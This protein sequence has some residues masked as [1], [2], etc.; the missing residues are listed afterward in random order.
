MGIF[1]HILSSRKINNMQ[2]KY[3]EIKKFA[4]TLELLSKYKMNVKYAIQ[5]KRLSK[6]INDEITILDEQVKN[7]LDEYCKKDDSGN[8]NQFVI[9]SDIQAKVIRSRVDIEII[10]KDS[11]LYIKAIDISKLSEKDRSFIMPT[12]D[13][14][15]II[16]DIDNVSDYN[17]E[18]EELLSVDFNFDFDKIPIQVIENFDI[19]PE[20]GDYI[21]MIF[22]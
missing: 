9:I 19:E 14:N 11:G 1:V 16:Y 2:M 20:F 10:K 6:I 22:E 21:E 4:K 12:I 18:M 13:N 3:Y 8:Y 7:I 15:T 5:L 17:K